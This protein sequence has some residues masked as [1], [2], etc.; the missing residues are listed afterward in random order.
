MS[1]PPLIEGPWLPFLPEPYFSTIAGSCNGMFDSDTKRAWVYAA[2]A[3][4]DPAARIGLY[5]FD[6]SVPGKMLAV[7]EVTPLITAPG[8]GTLPISGITSNSGAGVYAGKYYMYGAAGVNVEVEGQA[9]KIRPSV[10]VP[11]LG[12]CAWAQ[13]GSKLVSLGASSVFDNQ[14]IH[15]LDLAMGAGVSSRP[16]MN[17]FPFATLAGALF[18][19]G[20]WLFLVGG[21]LT[22]GGAAND[23]VYAAPISEGAREIIGAWRQVGELP[24]GWG[25]SRT[26]RRAPSIGDWAVLV[27]GHSGSSLNAPTDRIVGVELFDNGTM[28]RVVQLGTVPDT[29]RSLLVTW[30]IGDWL[31]IIGGGT[32][33]PTTYPRAALMTRIGS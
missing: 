30:V 6:L 16:M 8:G 27:G 5:R 4:A 21:H 24:A 25:V 26:G 31:Y 9:I 19:R 22:S 2:N 29:A 20:R 32:A 3:T 18:V 7:S 33:A 10:A 12:N 15:V 23:G 11:D 14:R 28:G 1:R 13:V 17:L